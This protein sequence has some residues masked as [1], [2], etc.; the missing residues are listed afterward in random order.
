MLQQTCLLHSL[1]VG[2]CPTWSCGITFSYGLSL[3]HSH[4]VRRPVGH[5]PRFTTSLT[6]TLE[7]E[8]T[9]FPKCNELIRSVNENKVLRDIVAPDWDMKTIFE[10]VTTI[11]QEAAKANDAK[12]AKKIAENDDA[13]DAKIAAKIAEND[14]ANDAKIAA[15]IAENDDAKIAKIAA[16]IAEND[17]ANDAKIA[18]NIAKIAVNISGLQN[19]IVNLQGKVDDANL[20]LVP[21][22]LDR[23]VVLA[24]QI[25]L[26]FDGTQPQENASPAKKFNS[27]VITKWKN[28][29]AFCAMVNGFFLTGRRKPGMTLSYWIRNLSALRTSRNDVSHPSTRA[30]VDDE[31]RLLLTYFKKHM[32]ST[33]RLL[34]AHRIVQGRRA[35]LKYPHPSR[36]S[37]WR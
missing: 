4:Q 20:L 18:A 29:P 13:N 24:T 2:V 30:E 22:A 32:P 17:A 1:C 19:E 21:L 16:K 26:I 34:L 31:A 12:L 33:D 27:A 35:I 15:K 3:Q 25:V 28:D 7:G 36:K 37:A 8:C 5:F 6:A 23:L 10:T 14:D 11:V 9:Q